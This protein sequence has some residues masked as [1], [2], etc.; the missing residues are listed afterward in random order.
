MIFIIM[1]ILYT[2]LIPVNYQSWTQYQDQGLY[3]SLYKGPNTKAKE[4]N[5]RT[6]LV[7]SSDTGMILTC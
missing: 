6:T 7:G 5:T 4:P 2:C 1:Y 3:E